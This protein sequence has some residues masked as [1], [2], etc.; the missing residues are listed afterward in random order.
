MIRDWKPLEW[1]DKRFF[2]KLVS[3]NPTGVSELLF[4][5]LY[6]WAKFRPV[7]FSEWDGGILIKT[8]YENH[9]RFFPPLGVND[10]PAAYAACFD[11]AEG[12]GW[13]QVVRRAPMEHAEILDGHG[14]S[15][16]PDRDNFDYI[17][18]VEDLAYLKGRHYDGK[19]GF[20]RKFMSNYD[21]SFRPYETSDFEDC[22]NLCRRWIERK[23]AADPA[24]DHEY[25][26]VR[27]LL[28]NFG[29]MNLDSGVLFVE[30]SMVAFTFGERITPDTCV[31]HFEKADTSY[32]GSYQAINFLFARDV[33]LGKYEY[34]N[35]EQDMGIPGLRKAKL[36]YL[37]CKY[38]EKYIIKR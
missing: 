38:V 14:Y 10:I 15:A 25:H 13:P 3:D 37:P 30:G 35:R 18:R 8:E 23:G 22:L 21:F 26:A 34:V 28:R 9:K 4:G 5:N 24:Y 6:I 17:Y 2:D 33:L 1:R 31:V 12:T 19:R 27:E 32:E 29:E 7:E 16:E 20:I 36:S 11:F